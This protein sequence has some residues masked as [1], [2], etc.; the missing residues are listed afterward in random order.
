[1]EIDIT[2]IVKKAYTGSP[3]TSAKLLSDD[4]IQVTI[5]NEVSFYRIFNNKL[6]MYKQ[7]G[8]GDNKHSHYERFQSIYRAA[9]RDKN[10][11]ILDLP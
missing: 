6:Y 9:N 8:V 7:D 2:D 10:I 4:F 3:I 1:M 5:D 11:E